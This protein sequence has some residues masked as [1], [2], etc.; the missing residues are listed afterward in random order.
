MNDNL[1]F[2]SKYLK[3][4]FEKKPRKIK[5]IKYCPDIKY[6]INTVQ[7]VQYFASKYLKRTFKKSQMKS[8]P[9]NMVL[10]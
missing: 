2:A 7:Y 8:G 1:Y 3:R 5:S 4:P 6:L 10:L 9:S